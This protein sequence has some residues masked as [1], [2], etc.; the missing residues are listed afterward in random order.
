VE[1]VRTDGLRAV[2]PFWIDEG[3]LGV[4]S[5]SDAWALAVRDALA[6]SPDQ[7]SF[8]E[9]ELTDGDRV[10]SFHPAGGCRRDRPDLEVSPNQ[11]LAF[12]IDPAMRLSFLF[13]TSQPL[14]PDSDRPS[15]AFAPKVGLTLRVPDRE[16][17]LIVAATLTRMDG[18]AF[19]ACIALRA[20]STQ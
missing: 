9:I 19:E 12:V 15:E 6:V 1:F 16:G 8:D 18:T 7:P 20:V 3:I 4:R 13:V 11:V 10:A 14:D 2:I 5:V 17:N